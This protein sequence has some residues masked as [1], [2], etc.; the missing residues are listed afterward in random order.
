MTD[1]DLIPRNW[2]DAMR[3]YL[4]KLQTTNLTRRWLGSYA[5]PSTF[6]RYA[7][8]S[9]LRATEAGDRLR[10]GDSA[11][12]FD[13]LSSQGVL[14]ALV[15]GQKAAAS[16]LD[17]LSGDESS[18]QRYSAAL[19]SGFQTYLKTRL[20]YY[21]REQRWPESVFWRRRHTSSG[22]LESTGQSLL[23]LN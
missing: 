11:I 5:A 9:Y 17:T 12:A 22:S 19:E 13:P 10:A 7:A 2:E 21:G 1:S 3:Y 18:M 16:I 20:I 23:S 6:R 8:D 14:N 4:G 15:T